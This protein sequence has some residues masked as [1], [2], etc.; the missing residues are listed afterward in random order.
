MPRPV[1]AIVSLQSFI[2]F[3]CFCINTANLGLV[4]AR[5][6]LE[7]VGTLDPRLDLDV[8]LFLRR[9]DKLLVGLE[10]LGGVDLLV[11]GITLGRLLAGRL[12][13]LGLE[14]DH[15]GGAL[16]AGG[17]TKVG[18]RAD[19]QV[20]DAVLLA[21]DGEVHDHV[22]GRDVTG[23]DDEAGSVGGRGGG[24]PE[25]ALLDGLLALFYATV[26]G[27]ELGAC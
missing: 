7:L 21:Q 22:H 12:L 3:L 10:V 1:V 14:H 26:D 17:D 13:A 8:P 15:R 20:G 27:L 9:L 25:G 24:G 4:D 18:A 2:F 16:G 11:I 5:L 23:N 6:D 19:V